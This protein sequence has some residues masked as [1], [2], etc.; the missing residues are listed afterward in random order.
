MLFTSLF[1][2]FPLLDDTQHFPQNVQTLFEIHFLT[3]SRPFASAR[4]SYEL[5]LIEKIFTNS[6]TE[7]GIT[8]N[9]TAL[10]PFFSQFLHHSVPG[11]RP[12]PIIDCYTHFNRFA[13]EETK[14]YNFL[15]AI[16]SVRILIRATDRKFRCI[17]LAS[18]VD[19]FFK[20]LSCLS[21]PFQVF[22]KDS[23]NTPSPRMT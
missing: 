15:R 5:S 2:L 8:A 9:V 13:H 4:I 23:S 17:S 18:N 6:T 7:K 21:T 3:L 1:Q 14:N 12:L 11:Y 16:F 19:P 20:R 22:Y 10:S